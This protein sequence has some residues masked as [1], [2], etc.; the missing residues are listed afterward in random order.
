[1]DDQISGYDWAQQAIVFD[2]SVLDIYLDDVDYLYNDSL[3]AII[4][5]GEVVAQGNIVDLEG[6]ILTSH[7]V[8]HVLEPVGD[9]QFPATSVRFFSGLHSKAIE[10][11]DLSILLRTERTFTSPIRKFDVVFDYKTA[12]E[13]NN[14]FRQDGK[15]INSEEI[16][17]FLAPPL[18]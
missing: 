12:K 15:L 1:M 4:W 9:P 3:F 5:N 11:R 14:H 13:I 18:E 7:P 2:D 6:P 16:E 8:M 10:I 17:R